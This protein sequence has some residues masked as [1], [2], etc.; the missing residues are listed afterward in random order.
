MSAITAPTSLSDLIWPND[1]VRLGVEAALVPGTPIAVLFHGDPGTGKTTAAGLLASTAM[2]RLSPTASNEEINSSMT[3]D[4]RWINYASGYGVD[5]LE[6][7][8]EW[9]KMYAQNASGRKWLIIDEID[10]LSPA[11]QGYLKPLMDDFTKRDVQFFATT[12]NLHKISRGVTDRML[13]VLM[14]NI[15]SDVL[16]SWSSSWISAQG[17]PPLSALA[18]RE[19]VTN[20]RGSV[21][22]V[23]RDLELYARKQRLQGEDATFSR[24]GD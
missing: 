6:S 11:A 21:R 17:L 7:S 22:H 10:N 5:V 16:I 23:R 14:D 8:S 15:A 18:L 4:V 9:S 24:G 19:L 13:T 12:N 3:T 2:R 20:A 1:D